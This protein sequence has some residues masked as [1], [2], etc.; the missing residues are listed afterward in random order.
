M[1]LGKE[2]RIVPFGWKP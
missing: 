2:H 1:L